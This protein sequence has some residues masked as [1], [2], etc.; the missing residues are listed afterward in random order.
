M[1]E[2]WLLLK[3]PCH[4]WV[5]LLLDYIYRAAA[6][7]ETHTSQ[8]STLMRELFE[9][10]LAD[11]G[12]L[13]GRTR[14]S[15]EASDI[16][17]A[18]LGFGDLAHGDFWIAEHAPSAIALA[19]YWPRWVDVAISWHWCA[20]AFIRLLRKPAFAPLRPSCLQWLDRKD[21]ASWMSDDKAP[22]ALIYLL[23]LVWAERHAEG[24]ELVGPVRD[25]FERLLGDLVARRMSEAVQL[26]MRVSRGE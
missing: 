19:P 26:S 12:W 10:A 5:D 21:R 8:F 17:R 20:S 22:L 18:F 4:D 7:V 25:L 11:G 15:F 2:P 6:Q 3:A 14:G 24:H 1:W 16:G 9:H 23:E 13:D